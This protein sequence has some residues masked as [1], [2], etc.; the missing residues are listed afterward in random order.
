MSF[1]MNI[2]TKGFP[3][4]VDS[5]EVPLTCPKCK[6]QITVSL[7]QIER[8]ETVQCHSCGTQ[9]SL[10]DKDK[11]VKK[12]TEDVQRS[13]DELERTLKRMGAKFG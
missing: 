4:N 12:G 8:E 3:V 2:R 5:W 6:A 13:L 9:I 7:D 11:S 1:K 10:K